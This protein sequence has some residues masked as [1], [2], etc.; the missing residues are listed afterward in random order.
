M[1]NSLQGIISGFQPLRQKNWKDYEQLMGEKGGCGGCWCMLFRLP[2][3]QFQ[4][5]KTGGNKIAMKE[6]AGASKQLGLIAYKGKEPIGW[7]A[8][9]PREEYIK[10]DNSR[11]FKR[12]DDKPVWSIT[13]FFIKKEYRNLG[14][15]KQL[16]KGAIDFAKDLPAGKAGKKI[17]TLEAYPAIPYSEKVPAPFLWVGILSAFTDN[18]FKVVQQNGKSRAM[19]RLNLSDPDKSGQAVPV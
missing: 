14:L 9:A 6:L 17:Q 2:D 8:F 16:I 7:I 1:D 15:S 10:L 5:N 12:I 18:G 13:C 11:S 4:A 3:K 19:V